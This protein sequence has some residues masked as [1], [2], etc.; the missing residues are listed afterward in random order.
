M[1]LF[2]FFHGRGA[3]GARLMRVDAR[4][5]GPG[6]LTTQARS[7]LRERLR[8]LVGKAEQKRQ[9]RNLQAVSPTILR[10]LVSARETS[11]DEGDSR[12]MAA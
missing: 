9:L 6:H 2:A 8:E 10:E 11:T 5:E 7:E 12:W 4:T 3:E 1:K